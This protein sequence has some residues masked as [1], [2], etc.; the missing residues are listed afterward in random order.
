LGDSMVICRFTA[1]KGFGKMLNEE[2]A[3]VLNHVTGWDM[4][5]DDL[6]TIG[7]RIYN[8]ERMINVRR[9]VSRK[10]DTLPY[11]VMNEPIPDG[12]A[13]GR[14]CPQETLDAMLDEYYKLRGWNADGIP[15]DAKLA[16]LG[17]K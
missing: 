14:C 2:L 10:D 12:P 16:E 9:G 4:G 6:E 13:R 5:L 15:T 3:K 1:E 11:R 17:L 8:L 7:E